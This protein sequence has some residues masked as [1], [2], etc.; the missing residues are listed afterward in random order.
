[1]DD[2]ATIRKHAREYKM[3]LY[4]EWHVLRELQGMWWR[5][6]GGPNGLAPLPN[7]DI[8]DYTALLERYERNRAEFFLPHG[9][10][11]HDTEKVY[12]NRD[13]VLPPSLYDKSLVNDG[14]AFTND[15]DNDYMMFVAPRKTGKSYVGAFKIIRW[16][17]KCEPTWHCFKHNGVSFRDYQGPKIVVIGSFSWTNVK[18]LWEVYR[19]VLPRY[20]LGPYA[21]DWGKFPGEGGR[22]KNLSFGDGKPKSIDLVE[23]QSRFI[24]LCYTQQQHVWE[25]FKA[26]ALHADEQIP[27]SLLTAWEDGTRTMGDYTPA[28][29]TLSGFTLPERPDTGMAGPIYYN[30]WEGNNTR[31]KSVGRYNNDMESTPDAIVGKKKKKQGFDQYV[32]PK[33]ERSEDDAKRGMACYYPGWQPGAGLVL[34]NFD[35]ST[36]IIPTYDRSHPL[37]KDTT[38]YRGTDHGLSRPCATVWAEVFPWGDICIYREYYK[39]GGTIPMHAVNIVAA[40]GNTRAEVGLYQDSEIMDARRTYEEV[41]TSERYMGSVLDGRSFASPSQEIMGTM[42][43]VY[44]Q[45]GLWCTAAKCSKSAKG[46]KGEMFNQQVENTKTYLRRDP[47]RPHIMWQFRKRKV[48]TEEQYQTWLE[49]RNG[50]WKFGSTI[51]FVDSL[52]FTFREFRQWGLK[53]DRPEDAN[54]HIVGGALQYLIAEMPRYFGTMWDDKDVDWDEVQETGEFKYVRY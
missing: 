31:G 15:D 40:S 11:W 45:Y 20:E 19:E 7:S 32:N 5:D 47:E 36:H 34:E 33:M 1:M 21:P 38:K 44:N 18:E 13:V 29:F 27:W 35:S 28:I 3:P 49:N 54:N 30:L 12:G 14:L 37:C 6:K 39:K 25:N 22:P 2:A 43:Q 42:G 10:P 46:A 41:F 53:N 50:E 4:G 9:V 23:S 26:G 17:C 8:K 16:A 24:F 52:D 48:I 51:Y